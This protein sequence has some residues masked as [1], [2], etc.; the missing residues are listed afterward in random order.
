MLKY[1]PTKPC[2]V[3]SA[4]LENYSAYSG[5]DHFFSIRYS[6]LYV[7]DF[8]GTSNGTRLGKSTS[9]FS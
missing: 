4:V 8:E 5:F 3:V 6:L 9:P 1:N 7:G 2:G